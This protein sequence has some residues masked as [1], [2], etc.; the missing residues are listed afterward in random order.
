M[1][2]GELTKMRS[3]DL[4]RCVWLARIIPIVDPMVTL[5]LDLYSVLL[6]YMS[7]NLLV[8]YHRPYD[9]QPMTRKAA[10]VVIG[11]DANKSWLSA[12]AGSRQRESRS[13][14]KQEISVLSRAFFHEFVPRSNRA[15]GVAWLS[16]KAWWSKPRLS[17]LPYGSWY[18][19]H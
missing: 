16:A 3:Q 2:I 6:T 1:R 10:V 8:A 15:F 7:Y 4:K 19:I 12:L 11:S 9:T 5:P 13:W 14:R 17:L 18:W